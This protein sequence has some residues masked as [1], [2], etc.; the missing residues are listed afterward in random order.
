MKT[1]PLPRLFASFF[2]IGSTS[3]G[4]TILQSLKEESLRQGIATEQ[5]IQEG[6]ALVQL[7][8]GPIMVDLAVF[9]GYRNRGTLG[10]FV[11]TLGFVLPSLVLIVLASEVYLRFG[12][13]PGVESMILGVGALVLG[14]VLHMTWD[15]AEANLSG[16]PEALLAL[17]A[18]A[19]A[20]LHA[21][22][23]WAILIGLA[24]GLCLHRDA[25]QPARSE[26]AEAIVW[27]R[28]FVPGELSVGLVV[29]A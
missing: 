27:S 23:L 26:K 28:L 19:L 10:A 18:F 17:L 3:F 29:V 15:F 25:G 20:V 16:I 21:N 14:V 1:I 7:Y 6:V 5:E 2:R 13:L 12:T 8:P 9:L 11:A 4:S 24:A 22:P